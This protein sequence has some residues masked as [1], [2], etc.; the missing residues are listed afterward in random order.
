M[1]AINTLLGERRCTP[2]EALDLIDILVDVS[3]VD[4]KDYLLQKY[5]S[6]MK[7]LQNKFKFM[8]TGFELLPEDKQFKT[9]VKVE[10]KNFKY[11]KHK[12]T[13]QAM[14]VLGLKC[15][16]C[17]NEQN[18]EYC[19]QDG[20]CQYV[21][22]VCNSLNTHVNLVSTKRA[23]TLIRPIDLTKA[24]IKDQRPTKFIMPVKAGNYW[25]DAYTISKEKYAEL[26]TIEQITYAKSMGY[27]VTDVLTNE[28]YKTLFRNFDKAKE[29]YNEYC[30]QLIDVYNDEQCTELRHNKLYM[31]EYKAFL[32]MFKTITGKAISN[33][34]N[35]IIPLLEATS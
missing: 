31:F 3:I 7:E 32:K 21:H 6:E 33:F 11:G 23:K 22:E 35:N 18:H 9:A 16:Y 34:S 15:L 10:Y 14:N 30:V 19:T 13:V 20:K 8:S 24:R 25:I 28:Y 27:D 4:N 29:L 5:P 26:S 17:N 1:L 2:D 12:M